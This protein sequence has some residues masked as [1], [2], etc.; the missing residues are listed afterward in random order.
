M[1]ETVQARGEQLTALHQRIGR[2]FDRVEPQRCAF[3]DLQA[4]RSPFER[5][6]GQ[7][8]PETII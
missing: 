5:K 4:L 3:A 8:L 6:N 1:I 2:H 7:R